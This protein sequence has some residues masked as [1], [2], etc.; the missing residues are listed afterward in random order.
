MEKK[1]NLR[2]WIIL[3]STA[4]LLFFVLAKIQTIM[5]SISTQEN[6]TKV[7]KETEATLLTDMQNQLAVLDKK[8]SAN[9]P[10][11]NYLVVNSTVN[12]FYLYKGTNLIKSD[13]CSTGSYILLKGND[14]KKQWMFKTPKGEFK[15]LNKTKDPVWKKPDWA[16]VEE[17]LPVPSPNH[18]SRFEYGV[19]G[20]YSL[21]IG[22]GY[23]IHGTLYQRFLGLPVT[24]GCIRLDDANLEL[25]YKSLPIGSK[26]FI[27]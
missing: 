12:E 20:D 18:S 22:D 26:V 15:I 24:H 14:N 21:S 27:F 1:R 5:V 23:L 2:K 10:R 4:V 6:V 25:V 11:N 19:L 13:I 9:I 16:F 7:D 3:G 17:G 8:L